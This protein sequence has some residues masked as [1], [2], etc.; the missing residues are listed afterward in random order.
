VPS[1]PRQLFD[2]LV[3]LLAVSVLGAAHGDGRVSELAGPAIDFRAVPS[4]QH[5][6]RVLHRIGVAGGFQSGD[7]FDER[8][9]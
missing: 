4:K 2:E 8:S 3:E 6:R 7:G 1:L 9:F 5:A